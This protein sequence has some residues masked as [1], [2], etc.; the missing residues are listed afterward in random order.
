MEEADRPDGYCHV[1]Y[2][3]VDHNPSVVSQRFSQGKS[4]ESTGSSKSCKSWPSKISSKSVCCS[5]CCSGARFL[6]SRL[7]TLAMESPQRSM[8]KSA[9]SQPHSALAYFRRARSCA[10]VVAHLFLTKA[11]IDSTVHRRRIVVADTRRCPVS[12]PS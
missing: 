4:R 12:A 9:R 2:V 5:C 7:A 6:L 11:S 10:S 8:Q 1:A 3:Y